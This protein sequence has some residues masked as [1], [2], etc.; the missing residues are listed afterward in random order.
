MIIILSA[1]LLLGALA[2][3][4]VLKP[5]FINKGNEQSIDNILKVSVDVPE[6]TTNLKGKEYVK[7]AFTVQT[8]GKKAK[9]EFEKRDFQIKNLMI[10]EL[11]EMQAADLQGKEGKQHLEESIKTKINELMQNGKIVKVYITSYIIS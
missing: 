8:D 3:I 10:T 1:V 2:I 6:I 5:D 11:S 9:E 4:I 7:I